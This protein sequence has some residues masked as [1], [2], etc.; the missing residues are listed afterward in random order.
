MI[1]N[2][3]DITNASPSFIAQVMGYIPADRI[4]TGL[5]P[6]LSLTFNTILRSRHDGTNLKR[7]FLDLDS[8]RHLA[9]TLI[10]TYRIHPSNPNL[11]ARTLSG[12][13]QQRL[14]I[15]REVSRNCN[16]IV[17]VQPTRGLDIEATYAVHALFVELSIQSVAVLLVSTDLEELLKICH[18]ILILNRGEIVGTIDPDTTDRTTIGLMMAGR[19]GNAHVD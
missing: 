7:W 6:S 14:L 1:L 12:G 4:G 10:D 19:K 9:Q 13:N 15:G 16:F 5:L 11:P 17:A 8:Y 3:E 2:G 18:R